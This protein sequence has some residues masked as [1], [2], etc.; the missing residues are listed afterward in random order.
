MVFRFCSRLKWLHGHAAGVRCGIGIAAGS[1]AYGIIS[2]NRSHVSCDVATDRS[3]ALRVVVVGGGVVGAS[4]A[5]SL[6][7]RGY[8]VTVVDTMDPF[9]SSWGETRIARLLQETPLMLTLMRRALVLWRQLEDDAGKPE[10]LLKRV[11]AMEIGLPDELKNTIEIFQGGGVQYELFHSAEE[12]ATRW[13]Q[14][15]LGDG[16]GAVYNE[17]GFVVLAEKCL[18]SLMDQAVRHGACWKMGHSLVS[19][20][21]KSKV[22]T[23]EEGEKLEYDRL[24]LCCG[25]WTNQALQRCDLAQLPL[26]VSCEQ[27]TYFKPLPGHESKYDWNSCPIILSADRSPGGDVY[28]I[29]HVVNGVSGIKVSVHREGNLMDNDEHPIPAGTKITVPHHDHSK[30]HEF[31][32]ECDEWMASKVQRW[33]RNHLPGVCPDILHYC[34]CRYTNV[35]EDDG[36]FVVGPHPH[37]DD[38]ILACA[39]NG[40]GF[41]FAT[42]VGEMAA[43]FALGLPAQVP[44]AVEPFKPARLIR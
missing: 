34:R 29:P 7:R 24:V 35:A 37:R 25:P 40:E 6:A 28:A 8:S 26:V 1:G 44:E 21:T 13:P 43:D 33:V 2:V 23:T 11:G 17:D 32:Q 4:A 38:V 20:D 19:C 36:N 30:I 39:F 22:L 18:E 27:Q 3:G 31:V 41:K 12:L 5:Y 10:Q 42:A 14:I 9:R 16:Q 15:R